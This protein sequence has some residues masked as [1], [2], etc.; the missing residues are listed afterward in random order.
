M[1]TIYYTKKVQIGQTPSGNPNYY[2]DQS[3]EQ[4]EKM[5]IHMMVA[6]A[7]FSERT[8]GFLDERDWKKYNQ[9]LCMPVSWA[10]G[11]HD[12]NPSVKCLWAQ[13]TKQVSKNYVN[14]KARFSVYQVNQFN[15]TMM[16]AAKLYNTHV[17]NTHKVGADEFKIQMEELKDMDVPVIGSKFNH[18]F[19]N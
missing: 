9:E 13:L 18:F 8:A 10:S 17:S 11:Q 1:Q 5:A 6:I 14:K 19:S 16:T 15:R 4:R 7:F 3:P 2:Y 12:W